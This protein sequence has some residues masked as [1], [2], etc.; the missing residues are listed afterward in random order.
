MS[1]ENMAGKYYLGRKV[2]DNY[3]RTL[4]KIVGYYTRD[5]NSP[6]LLGIE[7]LE[8][9]FKALP[10]TSTIDEANILVLDEN[11]KTKAE[12]LAQDITLIKR[13]IFALNKLYKNGEVSSDTYESLDKGFEA[14][15]QDLKSRCESFLVRL[16]ERSKALSVKLKDV[17]GYFVNVKL[18]H[19]IGEMDDEAYR[20]SG[21]ALRDLINRLQA[22]QKDIEFAQE[23]LQQTSAPLLKEEP[24]EKPPQ[25]EPKAI[26]SEVPIV[27]R[28]REAGE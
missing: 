16:G 12:S 24:L 8:G 13:K 27:L 15:D 5:K 20:V 4:G 19:E 18:A 23:S 11:W 26:P 28:I 6:P 3:G 25:I 10:S 22:E 1:Q 17:A 2:V 21:D 7:L 14:V 9:D